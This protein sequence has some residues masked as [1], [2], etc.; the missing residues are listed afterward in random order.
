MNI[1]FVCYRGNMHC[2]GQGIY[3]YYLTR[4]LARLGHN[5]DV[6]V[7]PPYPTPMEWATVH[8]VH[9]LNLWGRRRAFASSPHP[10]KIF[11]PLNFYELAVTAPGVLP[12]ML[13]FSLRAFLKLKE[14][15]RTRTFHLIH[16][17]QSLGYGL[18]LM[19]QLGPPLLSTVHHPLS[20]D[21]QISLAA[22]RSFTEKFYGITFYPP[23]M[24]SIVARRLDAILTASRSGKEAIIRELKVA[25]DKIITV[26]NGIDLS[27]FRP[28]PNLPRGETDI[29]FVGNAEDRKKGIR[30]LLEALTL[31][32]DHLKLTLVDDG[33]PHKT[34]AP[35]MVKQLGLE[36]RVLFTGKVSDQELVRLYCSAR[37]VV[38]PS[39]YEGFGLP[40]AEAMACGAPVVATTAGALPEVVED[41]VSGL[42]A[43]PA[44]P[45]ALAHAINRVMYDDRLSRSLSRA[46]IRRVTR[47]FGWPK[48]AEKTLEAYHQILQKNR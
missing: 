27:L 6:I 19:K 14:L 35:S 10:F 7:G 9:N 2:G 32:D 24:Q 33:L 20:I 26:G 17:V 3:L 42:L 37:V 30:Y 12:E 48:T 5:I 8:Q 31:L 46:G 40:A 1:C 18:L 36:Q 15:M 43:P 4:E 47:L 16:D 38:I 28:L 11:S 44:S 41:D 21:K 45:Q 34:L 13:T 39:L 29:L 25:P 22:K 23:A